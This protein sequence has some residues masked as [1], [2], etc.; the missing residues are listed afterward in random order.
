MMTMMFSRF[1]WRNRPS[2]REEELACV[3]EQPA[4]PSLPSEIWRRIIAFTVRLS[5]ADVVELDDAFSLPYHNE[6]Y[7]EIDPGIFQDRRNLQQV[8]SS[9]RE[10]VTEMSA[11]YLVIYTAKD[12]KA[13]VK[14]FEAHKSSTLK[15]KHLGEWTTRIDF[16]ILGKYSVVNVV[17]LLRC[18]PNLLI[19]NNRNGPLTTPERFT[20]QDV[21]KALVACCRHSLR[22]VEWSGAGEPPRYQDLVALCNALP[23][24]VTLRLTSIFSFPVRE[25]GIPPLMVLP[26]L[27]TLS[28]AVIPEPDEVRPEYALTWDPLLKYLSVNHMQLPSLERL[29]CDI[30]P[31]L[32]MNFFHMHGH[33]LRLFRTTAWSAENILPEALPLCP[34]LHSLV[35]S[36][37]SEN[38]DFPLFHPTLRKICIIPSVEATVGVPQRVFDYAVL[39]PLDSVLKSVEKM[40]APCLVEL[41]IR[42]M[43][44]FTNIVDYST[45]LRFWWR[46]WNIR[47]VQFRDKS[48]ISYANVSDPG[49]LLLDS[50]RG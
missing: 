43:G 30:F 47:G 16:R 13:L 33:K 32:T 19:Y 28:L 21:L 36:Q 45:W 1:S 18:T 9:W 15:G 48:G 41:R 44:A 27:K 3:A 35:I 4:L 10:A 2:S 40:V 7:P 17:R 39:S 12:L 31:L 22:R 14:Q 8:C 11:E 50:V 37:G 26:S 29:E 34:N 6:E 23:N 46:R 20:P 24:L 42:N 25:D 49:E 38:L 5:G